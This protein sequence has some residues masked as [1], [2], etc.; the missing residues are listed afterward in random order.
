MRSFDAP[1]VLFVEDNPFDVDLTLRG[2]KAVGL[3]K[4]V[5]VVRDGKEAVDYVFHTGP[6]EA[7]RPEE[8]PKLVLLD[9]KLPKM[10]GLQVL[11]WIRADPDTKGL[12]VIILT[13]FEDD[14]DVVEIFR[15]GVT[16]YLVKPLDVEKFY[17]MA[18]GL[19]EGLTPPPRKA[20]APTPA[21][22]QEEHPRV[23]GM[24]P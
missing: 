3:E 1:D 22:R 21:P 23:P 7:R 5:K 6:Y 19:L 15:L 8:A 9:L 24:D 20:A 10:T 17:E 12:P 4:R 16:G 13:T 11:Q 14:R 2:L 18:K